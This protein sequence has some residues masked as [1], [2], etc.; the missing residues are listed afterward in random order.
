[1]VLDLVFNIEDLVVDDLVLSFVLE[2]HVRPCP[3]TRVIVVDVVL[4]LEALVLEY[5]VITLHYMTDPSLR[6]INL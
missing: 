4:V 1:M 5:V 2:F 3:H 6:I